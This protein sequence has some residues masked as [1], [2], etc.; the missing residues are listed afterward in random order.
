MHSCG[1]IVNAQPFCKGA[2]ASKK[3]AALAKTASGCQREL[4]LWEPWH[5]PSL[6]YLGCSDFIIF[7]P[8]RTHFSFSV[9]VVVVVKV[10]HR[11]RER[12]KQSIRAQSAWIR[13]LSSLWWA[14]FWC[15]HE[16][17]RNM[18]RCWDRWKIIKPSEQHGVFTGLNEPLLGWIWVGRYKNDTVVTTRAWYKCRVFW[19][20]TLLFPTK[21]DEHNNKVVPL[22]L[23]IGQPVSDRPFWPSRLE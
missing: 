2:C 10:D 14:S 16:G 11:G 9:V 22:K 1:G 4:I 5:S 20:F 18:D 13:D 8:R 3:S 12:M 23:S 6:C 21:F 17:T 19:N 7:T 15:R